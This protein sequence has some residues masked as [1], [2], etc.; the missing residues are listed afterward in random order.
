MG[1]WIRDVLGG[2]EKRGV[3]R[4]GSSRGG[5]LQ[6]NSFFQSIFTHMI[7]NFAQVN[8]LNKC[9]NNG[10]VEGYKIKYSFVRNAHDHYRGLTFYGSRAGLM[11]STLK[12]GYILINS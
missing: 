1:I 2:R 5:A 6:T 12:K 8:I 3:D 7:S 11:V 4:N 9:L 10:K